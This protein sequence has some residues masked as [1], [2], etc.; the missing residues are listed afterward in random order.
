MLTSQTA[1]ITT[2]TLAS[3]TADSTYRVT[4]T[5]DCDSTSA[6]ATVNITIG[7]TDPSNTAQSQALGTNVVCTTLGSASVGNLTVAFRAKS[8]TNITYATTIVN[9]PTYDL[10]VSNPETISI[11]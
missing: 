11:N 7:W 5:L 3:V 1:A 4:A 10:V 2:T 9:T 8:G 6:A